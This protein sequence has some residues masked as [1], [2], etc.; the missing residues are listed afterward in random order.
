MGSRV[1]KQDFSKGSVVQ[2]LNWELMYIDNYLE[3]SNVD[4]KKI[5][6]S[7]VNNY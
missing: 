3:K 5:L 6:E 7:D 4:R 2:E 1:L